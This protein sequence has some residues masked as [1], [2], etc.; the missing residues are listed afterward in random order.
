MENHRRLKCHNV[1]K[2]GFKSSHPSR[3]TSDRPLHGGRSKQ[4]S[5]KK[6]P[7]EYVSRI[8]HRPFAPSRLGMCCCMHCLLLKPRKE[9]VFINAFDK[10]PYSPVFEQPPPQH[11]PRAGRLVLQRL[12][13]AHVLRP[14]RVGRHCS[15]GRLG[16]TC[17]RRP[18]A[19]VAGG[20][21]LAA[22]A[23]IRQPCGCG[24]G[25]ERG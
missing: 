6:L 21:P 12:S 16:H 3:R 9:L 1:S 25:G 19:L 8:S 5:R 14:A 18:A 13:N 20:A 22:A 15:R 17:I 7:C 4:R 11:G 2:S 23:A 24:G 10:R